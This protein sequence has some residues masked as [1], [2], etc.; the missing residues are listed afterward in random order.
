MSSKVR[1]RTVLLIL[2]LVVVTVASVAAVGTWLFAKPDPRAYPGSGDYSLSDSLKWAHITLPDCAQSAVRYSTYSDAFGMSTIVSLRVSS[3]RQCVDDFLTQNR[4]TGPA[5]LSI[6]EFVSSA[7]PEYGW[8]QDPEK[9]FSVIAVDFA[10]T[11]PLRVSVAA[12]LGPERAE[13]FVE[14]HSG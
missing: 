2:V 9:T 1:R 5:T 4:F 7:P 3:S 13:V 14:V 10:T 6:A 12:D 8:P 11:S